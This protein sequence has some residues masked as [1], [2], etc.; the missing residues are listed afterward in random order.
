MK[1]HTDIDI[2]NLAKETFPNDGTTAQFSLR[3]GF[4]VG[5]K[6]AMEQ[7]KSNEDKVVCTI[8]ETEEDEEFTYGYIGL[9][10]VNFCVWCLSGIQ[11]MC[12]Q[13]NPYADEHL[14]K[15]IEITNEYYNETSKENNE[16]T[17]N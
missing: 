8:C 6:K 13:L 4:V 9:M 2:E 7:H 10:P 11:D 1:E 17:T 14:Q 5:F 3:K 16:S 15:A 12:E